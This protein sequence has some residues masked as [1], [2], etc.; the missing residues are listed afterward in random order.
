MG[1]GTKGGSKMWTEYDGTKVTLLYNE[2]DSYTLL[3]KEPT[4]REEVVA[5]A[6]KYYNDS[7]E[8][9]TTKEVRIIYGRW[10][11]G[12]KWDNYSV[13]FIKAKKP[14]R[15]AFRAYLLDLE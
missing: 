10:I 2:D 13:R 1:M 5:I 8:P 15:G 12:S 4:T 14:A 3:A 7:D 9:Y 6:N 11:P